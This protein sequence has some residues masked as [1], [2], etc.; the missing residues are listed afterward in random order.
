MYL[1]LGVT[2]FVESLFCDLVSVGSHG[3][4]L[5]Y[6]LYGLVDDVILGV[7]WER[8]KDMYILGK[9]NG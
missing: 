3:L 5:V 1:M 8:L 7:V 2:C 4:N 9:G 6:C